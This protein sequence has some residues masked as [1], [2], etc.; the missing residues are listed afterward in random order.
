MKKIRL[1]LEILV[2]VL[3]LIDTA[4]A[5]DC[6]YLNDQKI[7]WENGLAITLSWTNPETTLGGYYIEVRDFNWMGSVSLRVTKNGEVKEGLLS[8]GELYLFNFSTNSEFEGL[9]VI[10][11]TVSNINSF[12]LNIGTYPSDPQ[13]RISTWPS[14]DEEDRLPVLELSILPEKETNVDSSITAYIKTQN[15]GDSDL[16]NTKVMIFYDN[17]DIMDDF[18]LNDGSLIK[19]TSQDHEIKWE[20]ISSY[21][22]TPANHLIIRNGYT[23]NIFNFS[24]GNALI[25]VTHDGSMKSAKLEDGGSAVFDFIKENEY[26]G[27]QILGKDIS[28]KAASLILQFPEKNSLKR[29]FPSIPAQGN[30]IVKLK[31]IMPQSSKR[32]YTISALAI[33]TD[34]DGN[35]YTNSIKETISFQNTLEVGK[36]SSNTI[37]NDKLYTDSPEIGNIRSIKN[38]THVSIFVN[39]LKDSPVYGINLTD[40]ILPGFHFKDDMNKTFI[41]WSFNMKAKERKEFN[42]ELIPQRKG[43]YTLP[44]ADLTWPE[45]GEDLHLQSNNPQATVSGPY[46]V[47]ERRFNRSTITHGAA[48]SVTLLITNVGDLPEHITINDIVP[49]NASLVSGKSSFSGFLRPKEIARIEYVISVNSSELNFKSPE[50]IANNQ[51]YQWYEPLSPKKISEN[52]Q[53]TSSLYSE[54][55][56]APVEINVSEKQPDRT[57]IQP[58]NEELSWFEQILKIFSIFSFQ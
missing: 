14:I 12:P 1:L 17:L 8:E 26:L 28:N 50:M 46:I 3:I 39:N 35:N 33:G 7:C 38:T 19:V 49:E 40:T 53:A 41:S 15:S 4:S 37:L 32:T 20:N 24:N 48:L 44:K 52:S 30:E 5:E 42:Y 25:N 13:V 58:V 29:I 10:A 9:K 34:K 31:F 18:S 56:P 36:F 51:G 2:L 21:V 47:M 55:T 54:I 23:I 43:I 6:D 57:I 22:L 11:D 45:E 16:M 27:I